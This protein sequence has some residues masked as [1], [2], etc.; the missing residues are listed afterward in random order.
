[1]AIERSNSFHFGDTVRTLCLATVFASFSGGLG[2][3]RL[4]RVPGE[5]HPLTQ[6]GNRREAVFFGGDGCRADIL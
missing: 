5:A 2:M 3:A 1:L 6:R 4:A